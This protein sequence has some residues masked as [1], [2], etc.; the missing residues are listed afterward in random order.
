MVNR[1]NPELQERLRQAEDAENAV[2][3]LG[4]LAAEAPIL[5]VELARAQRQSTWDRAKRNA[6][7]EA[8]RKMNAANEKQELVPLM[9]E[10]VSTMVSS[11]Y[12][13]F[14]EI[15]GCRR[16]AMEH[17]SVVDKV[18]YEAELTA[19]EAEQVQMGRDP[20]NVEYLVASHHGPSRVR[21]L[22]E[23]LY[24]DFNHLKDCD[25]EDPMRREVAQFILSHVISPEQVTAQFHNPEG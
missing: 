16:E 1:V 2:Q 12:G 25:L 3:K 8:Q 19:S 11:L 13:L 7:E 9:L 23:E 20:A 14:K 22:M 5:R 17:I 10:E 6:L 4:S 21:K 15:E 18:D 24:P